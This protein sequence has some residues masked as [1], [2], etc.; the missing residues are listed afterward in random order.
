MREANARASNG[1]TTSDEIA[2]WLAKET[3]KKR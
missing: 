3:S 2:R 1:T